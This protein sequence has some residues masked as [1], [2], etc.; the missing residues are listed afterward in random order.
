MRIT[1]RGG[2]KAERKLCRSVTKFVLPR[3]LTFKYLNTLSLTIT[4]TNRIGVDH[5]RTKLPIFMGEPPTKINT[6]IKSLLGKR[7]IILALC[8]ELV[9]VAQIASGRLRGTFTEIKWLDFKKDY[10]NV[11]YEL[12]PF[13]KEAFEYQEILARDYLYEY[14]HW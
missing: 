7:S 5:G 1:I 8:H 4:L 10:T 6:Q 11:V 2:T 9:H 13:E 3:L 12:Q 14:C